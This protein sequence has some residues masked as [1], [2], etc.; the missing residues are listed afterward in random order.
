M[1]CLVSER[2]RSSVHFYI[3]V[4]G[5]QCPLLLPRRPKIQPGSSSMQHHFIYSNLP[6]ILLRVQRKGTLL[7][8]H[9]FNKNSNSALWRV[10]DKSKPW[11]LFCV[12]LVVPNKWYYIAFFQRAVTSQFRLSWDATHLWFMAYPLKTKVLIYLAEQQSDRNCL[13]SDWQV[14]DLA[15]VC[16]SVYPSELWDIHIVLQSQIPVIC[17]DALYK[18]GVPNNLNLI[19]NSLE[20]LERLRV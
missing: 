11:A 18:C 4:G 5:S 16:R 6:G 12:I 7:P 14:P 8:S 19:I 9:S 15:Q 1:F 17:F 10:L 2:N 13:I 3:A 20:R